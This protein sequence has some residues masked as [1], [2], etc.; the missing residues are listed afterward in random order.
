[1]LKSPHANLLVAIIDRLK[2]KAPS[3]RFIAQDIGQLEHYEIRPAVSWPC[4]LMDIEQLQY[5]DVNDSNLQL[6]QGSVSLRIGMVKYTD[7]N[8]LVPTNVMENALKYY[9]VENE[10]FAALHGWKPQGFGAMLRR[11]TVTERRED[12]IRV[13]VMHFAISFTDESAK[14]ARTTIPRPEGTIGT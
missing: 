3:L 7:S 14:I 4:C 8:N 5:S 13:R 12:D 11:S 1:M 9:E 10:V 2:V 6:A